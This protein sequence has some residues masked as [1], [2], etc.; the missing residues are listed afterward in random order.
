MQ[1]GTRVGEA[2]SPLAHSPEPLG[3]LPPLRLDEME[4]HCPYVRIP[5]RDCIALPVPFPRAEP[6]GV[7]RAL[8]LRDSGGAA[9]SPALGS[10]YTTGPLPAL[11]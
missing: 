6:R 5:W 1:M 4:S 3:F 7:L 2:A 11:P 8:W 10:A 9:R